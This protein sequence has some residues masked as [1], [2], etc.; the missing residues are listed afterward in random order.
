MVPAACTVE[1]RPVCGC[2]FMT[3]GNPCSAAAAGQATFAFSACNG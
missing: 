2:D 1:F 3:Y